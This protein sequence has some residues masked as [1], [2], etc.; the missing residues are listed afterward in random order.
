MHFYVGVISV[1]LDFFLG[2]GLVAGFFGEV[3]GVVVGFAAGLDNGGYEDVVVVVVV[4]LAAGA[5]VVVGLDAGAGVVVGV[6]A[7]YVVEVG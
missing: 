4:G 3:D 2:D 1:V 6:E 5:G 7:G